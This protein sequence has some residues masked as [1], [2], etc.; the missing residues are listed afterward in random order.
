MVTTFVLRLR[1]ESL[2][3][4][5]VVGQVEHVASGRTATIRSTNELEAFARDAVATESPDGGSAS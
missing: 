3:D 4:G 5:E 1:A 2:T